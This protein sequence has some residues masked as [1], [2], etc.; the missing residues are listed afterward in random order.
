MVITL[1]R[2]FDAMHDPIKDIFFVI[3]HDALSMR[4][5]AFAL[6][7]LLACAA[8]GSP[9]EASPPTEVTR[10]PTDPPDSAKPAPSPAVWPHPPSPP[11]TPGTSPCVP[12]PPWPHQPKEC[13]DN[14]LW[15][16]KKL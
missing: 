16:E 2:Y 5:R 4:G 9:R 7:T 6:L 1:H 11:P 13:L 14:W 15:P 10:E 12:P 3:D 8:C